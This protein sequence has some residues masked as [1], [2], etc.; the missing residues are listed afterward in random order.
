M[1]YR[2]LSLMDALFIETN[3]IPVKSALAMLGM[4]NDELRLPLS[5]LSSGNEQKLRNILIDY[6]LLPKKE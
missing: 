4:I 5:N 6:G 3:P 2:M 1:H